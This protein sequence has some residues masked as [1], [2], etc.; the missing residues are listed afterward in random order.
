[1][2][3]VSSFSDL[4]KQGIRAGGNN[5]QKKG[6]V[7]RKSR[8]KCVRRG[9]KTTHSFTPSFIHYVLITGF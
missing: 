8:M 6:E 2:T 4:A 5:F 7:A 3:M 1:M 9:R